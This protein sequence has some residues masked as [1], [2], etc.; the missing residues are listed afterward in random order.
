M[1]DKIH[2]AQVSHPLKNRNKFSGES[3]I[4]KYSAVICKPWLMVK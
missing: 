3:E 2:G 4:C 1:K